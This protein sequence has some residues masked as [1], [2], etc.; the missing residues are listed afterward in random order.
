M[1]ILQHEKMVV[2]HR[3][4]ALRRKHKSCAVLPEIVPA[5]W[6]Q[7]CTMTQMEA[8]PGMGALNPKPTCSELPPFQRRAVKIEEVDLL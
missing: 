5:M 8:I 7:A 1:P 4:L 3:P 6:L 2:R